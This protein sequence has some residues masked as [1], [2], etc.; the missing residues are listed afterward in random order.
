MFSRLASFP[1]MFLHI[2]IT[3]Q[4]HASLQ[5]LSAWRFKPKLQ[6]FWHCIPKENRSLI[7]S[8][9]S[10]PDVTVSTELSWPPSQGWIKSSNGGAS[11]LGIGLTTSSI[12]LSCPVYARQVERE[13][14]V[15]FLGLFF[16]LQST[17][18][19]LL[20]YINES[21]DRDVRQADGK[22]QFGCWTVCS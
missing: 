1:V 22:A 21:N 10:N 9:L 4:N 17:S 16:V 13:D 15:Y 6:H 2:L 5:T 3:Y 18:L 19:L 8:N 14:G 7:S 20:A 12:Q 11:R